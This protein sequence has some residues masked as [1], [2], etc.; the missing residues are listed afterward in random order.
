VVDPHALTVW[1][2]ADAV[3]L[4]CRCGWSAVMPA[5]MEFPVSGYA[6]VAAFENFVSEGLQ[7]RLAV[8][9]GDEPIDMEPPPRP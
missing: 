6:Y 9:W 8:C 4:G 1:L 3:V 2:R 5:E 7:H